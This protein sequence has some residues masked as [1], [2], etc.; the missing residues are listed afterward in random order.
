MEKSNHYSGRNVWSFFIV[1]FI[2]SWSL[3][4][5]FVLAGLGVVKQSELLTALRNP[6]LALGAFAPLFAAVTMIVGKAGWSEVRKFIKQAFSFRV[7]WIYVV[8]SL[9]LPLIITAGAHYITNLTG[10]DSLPNT[11]LPKD[12]PV[13]TIILIIPYFVLMF[14]VGGGQEEFGWRGY[15]QEPLQQRFGVVRGSIVLGVVWGIW[16]LPLWFI[17][18]DGH[19]YYSFLAFILYTVSLSLIIAVLYNVSGKKLIVPW[20]IHAM[21]NTIVP[22]FPI[23]HM[24]NVPQPGYWVWT[25]LNALV[26][27]SF[28]IWFLNTSQNS[29][30]SEVIKENNLH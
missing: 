19:A 13:P 3:W 8:L 20:I 21:G 1:T 17:P 25:V 4:L 29:H 18:G 5:P 9:L 22:F 16:H 12:L 30:H 14:L 6:A 27:I 2:Y 15:A 11:L 24:E 10:I 7:K 28:T 23:I 26:A